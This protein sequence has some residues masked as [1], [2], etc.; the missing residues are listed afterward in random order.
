MIKPVVINLLFQQF[1]PPS[2]HQ[3]CL[4][5]PVLLSLLSLHQSPNLDSLGPVKKK[6]I[7]NKLSVKSSVKGIRK[8]MLNEGL[9]EIHP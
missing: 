2:G 7:M 1:L 6:V 8:Q 4:S 5:Y 3:N 9:N